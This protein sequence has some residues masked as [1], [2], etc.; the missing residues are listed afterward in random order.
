MIWH[1]RGP[2]WRFEQVVCPTF[3]AYTTAPTL[4]KALSNIAYKYK[5]ENGLAPTAKVE[6]DKLFLDV[7]EI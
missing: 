7:E 5:E 1:Y 6:L 3:E 2:V 4:G